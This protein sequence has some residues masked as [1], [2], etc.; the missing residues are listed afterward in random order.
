MTHVS[1]EPPGDLDIEIYVRD[2]LKNYACGIF[3]LQEA[4]Q[5]A[6]QITFEK[7]NF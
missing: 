2:S 4:H 1:L 5:P 6:Y 7:D 3:S